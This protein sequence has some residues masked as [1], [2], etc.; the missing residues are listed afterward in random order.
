M[1]TNLWTN[2][3]RYTIDDI[4][5]IDYTNLA[6]F[7]KI[8]SKYYSKEYFEYISIPTST[9]FEIIS[10]IYYGT[11]D[12]WDIIMTFNGIKSLFDLPQDTDLIYA[13]AEEYYNSWYKE[14]Q[15]VKPYTALELSTKKEEF[16]TQATEEN[17]A[18]RVIKLIKNEYIAEFLKDMA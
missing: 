1:K 6:N 15:Y 13:K 11:P 4:S 16:I 17:E 9:R 14:F 2:L 3:D 12:Y 8:P 10:D 5:Y 7:K 18:N